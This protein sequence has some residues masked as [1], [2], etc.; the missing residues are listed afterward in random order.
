MAV[1][2]DLADTPALITETGSASPV[3]SATFTPPDLSLVVVMAVAGWS[4]ATQAVITCSDSGSHTWTNSIK[5]TGTTAN[6]GTASIFQHYFATSPGPITVSTA[7]SGFA[8]GSGGIF[9]DFAVL[10][11]AAASQ[12]GAATAS[13]LGTTGLDGTFNLTTTKKNSWMW[14]CVGDSTNNAVWTP[15]TG[16]NQ[17]SQWNDATDVVTMASFYVLASTVGTYTIGGTYAA[18]GA[19]N[20]STQNCAVEILPASDLPIRPVIIN[21]QAIRSAYM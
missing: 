9:T 16:N 10:L 2:V 14:G 13:K 21:T 17:W 11:G 5:A 7:Y 8:S 15:T 12:T 1:S 4:G 19:T 3:T 20:H 18:N 6:G